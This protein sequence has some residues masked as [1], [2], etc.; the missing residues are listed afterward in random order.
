M[1]GWPDVSDSWSVNS[2]RTG[3]AYLM[4][5]GTWKGSPGWSNRR[6]AAWGLSSPGRS[7]R[8][9]RRAAAG[10]SR[11][12]PATPTRRPASCAMARR[13]AGARG[14]GARSVTEPAERRCATFSCDRP[15]LPG[16]LLCGGCRHRLLYGAPKA[17]PVLRRWLGR[18]PPFRRPQPPGLGP[19]RERA[20][21]PRLPGGRRGPAPPW[22][23]PRRTASGRPSTGAR[24]GNG[25][26]AGGTTPASN[27]SALRWPR[28]AAPSSSPATRWRRRHGKSLGP[29]LFRPPSR[30]VR[31]SRLT[32]SAMPSPVGGRSLDDAAPSPC[33]RAHPTPAAPDR[34]LDARSGRPRAAQ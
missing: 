27:T 2:T 8:G 10:I 15:A 28:I 30:T 25:M 23:I 34:S 19:P 31:R 29:S 21:P 33:R 1:T 13:G 17:V 9:H 6:T 24:S 7:R 3:S 12:T 14:P 4:G 20:A 11:V 32:P 22:W 26:R 16:W 5:D 18:D